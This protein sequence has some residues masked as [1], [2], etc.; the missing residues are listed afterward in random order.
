MIRH[1]QSPRPGELTASQ[2]GV[3]TT[4]E[5]R[6][7]GPVRTWRRELSGTCPVLPCTQSPHTGEL[8][9]HGGNCEINQRCVRKAQTCSTDAISGTRG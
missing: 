2:L 3:Q 5:G 6:V 1:T 4:G 9:F 7:A 8:C